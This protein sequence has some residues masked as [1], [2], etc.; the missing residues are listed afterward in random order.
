[1][2]SYVTGLYK[3]RDYLLEL[4]NIGEDVIHVEDLEKE[5]IKEQMRLN[6]GTMGGS[7]PTDA[8][9]VQEGVGVG[10]RAGGSETRT[11]RQIW[12]FVAR[13]VLAQAD[14]YL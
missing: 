8:A 10:A 12:W 9:E 1:M 7:S 14:Q 4:V 2:N 3:T 5:R 11:N 6:G 13:T